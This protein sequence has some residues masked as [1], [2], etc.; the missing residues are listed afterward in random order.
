MKAGA[1][2]FSVTIYIICAVIAISLIMA[3]RFL[4]VFGQDGQGAELG[5]NTVL[6]YI[7]ASVL[8]FLWFLYVILS[9]SSTPMLLPHQT[10]KKSGEKKR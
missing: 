10:C 9:F 5:G 4:P 1:L 8:L 6:K 2:T 7:S 3:R